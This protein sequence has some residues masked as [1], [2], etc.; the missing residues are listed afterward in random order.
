MQNSEKTIAKWN[1]L[2]SAQKISFGDR[3]ITHESDLTAWDKP[4]QN[5][6][7]LK[8]RRVLY[9]LKPPFYT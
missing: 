5:L 6:S 8:Q 3:W 2:T 9:T 7:S 4:F 1:S